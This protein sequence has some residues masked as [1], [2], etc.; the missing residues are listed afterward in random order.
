[1]MILRDQKGFSIAELLVV[2]TIIGILAL[3]VI[4]TWLAYG[5]AATIAGAAREVQA[6]LNQA[7]QL[8]ISTRQ[9]VCV[10]VV[11]PRGYQFMVG[12]AG[13]CAGGAA[14]TG[15]NTDGTGIF[16][17]ANQGVTIAAPPLNPVFTPFGTAAQVAVFT[18]TGP[19]ARQ[20]TV[21]VSPSGRVTIP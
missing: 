11:P 19:Q 13:G 20:Q 7:R 18:V 14:W 15:L 1:M 12:V 2:I 4:P 8:A 10:R 17:L 5:P 16:W 21:T 9:N 3:I 6:G